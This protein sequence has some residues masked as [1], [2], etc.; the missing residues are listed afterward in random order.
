M[1]D[2]AASSFITVILKVL[3]S[4]NGGGFINKKFGVGANM[5]G[6]MTVTFDL[7][8]SSEYE[9][10][11]RLHTSLTD[12][13]I[14][15]RK[16]W[17]PSCSASDELLRKSANKTVAEPKEKKDGEGMWN[18]KFK[19]STEEASALPNDAGKRVFN[20]KCND[21]TQVDNLLELNGRKW[22]KSIV[23]LSCIY[24]GSK[25]SYGFSKR[26]RAMKVFPASV[27]EEIECDDD[28]S[29]EDE[30]DEGDEIEIA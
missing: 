25:N 4:F 8:D 26:M 21:G 12:M 27:L 29:S 19:S 18:G 3:I 30:A 24:T 28:S 10:A 1:K 2:T 20:V 14:Q 23:E 7:A 11:Q 15:K 22:E 17:F 13:A 5:F 9:A 6:N 16:E